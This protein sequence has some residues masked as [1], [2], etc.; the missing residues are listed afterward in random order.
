MF[1]KKSWALLTYLGFD[2]DLVPD[3]FRNFA[4]TKIPR[5]S[6]LLKSGNSKDISELP[7]VRGSS[8]VVQRERGL[9]GMEQKGG[10]AGGAPMGSEWPLSEGLPQPPACPLPPAERCPQE[11]GGLNLGT[12]SLGKDTWRTGQWRW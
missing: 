2:P 11:I 10:R 6:N 4:A 3:S 9:D 7:G 8:V 12:K 5:C 1:T